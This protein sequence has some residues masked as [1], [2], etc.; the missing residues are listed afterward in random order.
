M[1]VND[2]R[3]QVKRRESRKEQPN[4]VRLRTNIGSGKVA[5]SSD[6]VD[7][8]VVRWFGRWYVIPS[9][10]IASQSG[11]VGNGIYMPSVG[12]WIDRWDVLDGSRVIYAQQKCFDF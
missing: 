5:Y 12:E 1:K 8:F 3:V 6:D 7:V 9:H 11:E 2:I 4:R 10:A